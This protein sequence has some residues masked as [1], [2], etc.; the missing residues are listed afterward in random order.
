MSVFPNWFKRAYHTWKLLLGA[1]LVC[2]LGISGA[3]ASIIQLDISG[4]AESVR[5]V[6]DPLGGCGPSQNISSQ[7]ALHLSFDSGP[8]D[9]L[10]DFSSGQYE[11]LGFTSGTFFVDQVGTFPIATGNTLV[12]WREGLP[13][14]NAITVSTPS[15][16]QKVFITQPGATG[17]YQF[18]GCA[19]GD[20]PL[21][22]CRGSL[23]PDVAT[24]T[25]APGI[26]SAVPGPTVGGGLLGILLACAG[27]VLRLRGLQ[28]LT[29][30]SMAFAG[31]QS[32]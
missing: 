11:F 21:S 29:G 4:R 3:S 15:L 17:H 28:V 10:I 30:R 12:T 20:D 7:F 6:C 19:P 31:V 26:V 23:S 32:P 8:A 24:L 16:S 22:V 2:L 18:V 13:G 1:P 25:G 5:F 14:E 27:L 9:Q